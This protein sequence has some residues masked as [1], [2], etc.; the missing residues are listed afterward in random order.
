M[1]R[2]G[3]RAHVRPGDDARGVDRR[4]V[5]D[6]NTFELQITIATKDGKLWA[7][8]KESTASVVIA[9]AEAVSWIREALLAKRV[10]GRNG[11]TVLA[12]DVRHGGLFAIPSLVSEYRAVHDSPVSEFG[13]VSVWLV[14]PAAKDCLQLG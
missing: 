4:L 11:N 10:T 13:F 12:I 2:D 8:A 14:G 7:R 9:K 1:K 3:H 6:D 5:V